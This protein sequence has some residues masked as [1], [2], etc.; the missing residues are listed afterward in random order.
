MHDEHNI[1]YEFHLCLDLFRTVP[2]PY[3][4][5]ENNSRKWMNILVV[6]SELVIKNH[7]YFDR[8]MFT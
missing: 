7:I 4:V 8:I 6:L 5:L 3:I 1:D 2:N